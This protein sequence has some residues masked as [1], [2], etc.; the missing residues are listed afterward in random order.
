MTTQPGSDPSRSV[1]RRHMHERQAVVF[2]LLVAF[3]AITGIGA[4]AV[5]TGAVEPPFDRTF[6]SPKV[7]DAIADVKAPCLAEGTLPIPYGEVQ[8]RIFNASGKGGMAAANEQILE[9]RG[10]TV[11]TVGDLQTPEGKNTTQ[12]STQISFGV[13]GISQAYTLAAHYQDPVLVLD[14]RPDASVDLV[15]GEN[16]VN[17][18]DE[19]LV[20]IDPAVPLVNPAKCVAVETITP[21]AAYVPP[22]PPAE[23]APADV[24]PADEAPT[25][26]G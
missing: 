12:R 7:D 20:V 4:L 19:E 14:D 24:D 11:A 21:Q 13:T 1:R 23:E 10:F 18:V 15:L 3:L 17:L 26:G 2:G 25:V 16:F 6:S 22:T 5:Y 9:S 8:V